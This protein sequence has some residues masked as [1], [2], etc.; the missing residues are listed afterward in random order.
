ML[1]AADNLQKLTKFT[2][3]QQSETISTVSMHIANLVK[4]DCFTGTQDIV[5][6]TAK[7][8]MCCGQITQSKID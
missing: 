6:F 1:G 8:W 5:L 4:N 2:N 7:T 3:E